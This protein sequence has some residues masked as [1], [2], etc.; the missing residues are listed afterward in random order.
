MS[1]LITRTFSIIRRKPPK[2]EVKSTK[3]SK[4]SLT[5][6][7]ESSADD[8]EE[9]QEKFDLEAL[10]PFLNDEEDNKIKRSSSKEASFTQWQ[11]AMRMVVRLPG[12]IPAEFRKKVRFSTRL[13]VAHSLTI[14]NNIY[15]SIPGDLDI[16]SV[17]S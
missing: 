5:S 10:G 7:K 14:G 1:K 4:N 16:L 8:D 2:S 11:E 17:S 6:S 13:F 9:D 15:F 3:K 12:G